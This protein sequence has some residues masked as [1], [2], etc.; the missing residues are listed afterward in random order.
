MVSED[1]DGVETTDESGHVSDSDAISFAASPIPSRIDRYRVERCLGHGGFGTV[2]LAQD[3]QL[4]RFVAIKVPKESIATSNEV[5]RSYEAE[6]RAVA[7]LD[8]PN[9][10][11]VYDIGS[12][13]EFPCFVVSKYIEGQ[14]LG[15]RLKESSFSYKSL[16][17]LIATIA[18]ALHYGHGRGLIHRDIKPR[19][20]L[21]D[22]DNVPYIVDYG[23]A[24]RDEDFGSGRRGAGT[25]TYMSPEQA[26]GESHLVDGRSDIFSL[27]I[28]FFEAL[29]GKRPFRGKSVSE[30]I[31]Q[32]VRLDPRP[33]RQIDDLV[34]RELERICLKALEKR[35]T[36]RYATASDMADD[37]RRFVLEHESDGHGP[38]PRSPDTP[39]DSSS[40]PKEGELPQ[41]Y[42]SSG[43]MVSVI[44]RGLRSFTPQDA[45]FY[46]SLVPGPRDRVGMPES[47]AAW[48]RRIV[49]SD[50]DD[51]IS[52][53]M[54]YGPSGCGKSSFVKAGLLP[55]LGSAVDVVFVEAAPS[56]TEARLLNG[57]R[58]SCS[59]IPLE[60]G[61]RDSMA[62]LRTNVANGR[63][64]LLVIDQFEQWLH[65]RTIQGEH[66]LITALRQCDGSGVQCIVL[67]RDDFWMAATRFMH[68]LD[69]RLLE[70]FNSTAIDTFSPA[71]AKRVLAAFARAYDRVPRDPDGVAQCSRFLDLAIESLT[72][73]GKLICVRLAV[74]AE[75][76]K[77]RPWVPASLD[78]VGGAK[79]LGVAFLDESFSREKAPL[80]NRYHH[81]AAQLVLRKLLPTHGA[82]IIGHMRS[83]EELF[84]ASGYSQS[85][86]FDA[87][88]DLLDKELRLIT[89][90]DREGIE[91]SESPRQAYFQLSHDFLVPS[92]RLWLHRNQKESRQGRAELRL[93]EFSSIWNAKPEKQRLPS[94]LDGAQIVF[95]TR[96]S[97]RSEDQRKM[98][99]AA[100]RHHATR[101]LFLAG[102]IF[103]AWM[104]IAELR[105]RARSGPLVQQLRTASMEHVSNILPATESDRRWI[106]EDLRRL[107]LNEDGDPEGALRARLALANE[108]PGHASQLR[109]YLPS[110]KTREIPVICR[111]LTDCGID[112]VHTMLGELDDATNAVE[113]RFN[114]A[115]CLS[116]LVGRSDG[117]DENS[118]DA[119][120]LNRDILQRLQANA[121]QIADQMIARVKDRP[122]E[123]NVL[124]TLLYPARES[125]LNGFVGAFVGNDEVRQSIASAI[126]VDYV[127]GLAQH[128]VDF[129]TLSNEE[130]YL[131]L[132]PMLSQLRDQVIDPLR[133][134][135]NSQD[136]A[137]LPPEISQAY[138]KANALVSLVLLGQ[139]AE[140][141]N[142]L[143]YTD[144][145]TVRNWL[146]H[147]FRP[148]GVNP[149]VLVERL[150]VEDND[151]LRRALIF[152]LGQYN[153]DDLSDQQRQATLSLAK[154]LF[155]N[156]HDA[157][158]HGSAAWLIRQWEKD[159]LTDLY[160]G[161][162]PSNQPLEGHNW[163]INREGHTMVV[164]DGRDE[165]NIGHEFEIAAYE[166]T[167]G[168]MLRWLPT[169]FVSRKNAPAD[170]CPAGL[171][172]WHHGIAYCQWLNE[173][174]GIPESEYCYPKF[175]FPGED[176]PRFQA[177]L[178]KTGYRL[179]T[180][181]EWEFACRAGTITNSYYGSAAEL[182][183]H[184]TWNYFNSDDRSHP[185]G[186]K[187][188]NAWGL[189][190]LHGNLM[191]WRADVTG[192]E[193]QVA[194]GGGDW[195]HTETRFESAIAGAAV[196]ATKFYS[197]GFR[198]ARTSPK[199]GM[200]PRD[201]VTD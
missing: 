171:M 1:H 130:Q 193:S 54:I 26:R 107:A 91:Q 174:M 167:T 155:S 127:A 56:E 76:M 12:T 62:W 84:E 85:S 185:V 151:G 111:R 94:L 67:I 133:D 150:L 43:D 109:D 115:L 60:L 40:V 65:S 189:F 88:M 80:Q 164:V 116:W 71:H 108:D 126:V 183:P 143:R 53:G 34:P 121:P 11:P 63:K 10:V 161:L 39:S 89:P 139:T 18:D 196:P 69:K 195:S 50:H 201:R 157:G 70:G 82:D 86:D 181:A 182:Y 42:S 113:R 105:G 168:Q 61:L 112:F 200:F 35:V 8:H 44:P 45:D 134:Q 175:E 16:A 19:N 24:L 159:S 29:V 152:A 104:G 95:H 23:L 47:V 5:L 158:V 30:I 173:Q 79:G 169:Q 66:E 135:I 90:S 68:E 136:K 92:L 194:I 9:I 146:I 81:K 197:Y 98:I 177:D 132:S 100:T 6:A 103:L 154:R 147:R 99:R 55:Q 3:E 46:L 52:M 7:A 149:S 37:L 31:K 2:Y 153:H 187:K 78:A 198:I 192:D 15:D 75:M 186:F 166:V 137:I 102:I 125:I 38:R 59:I 178:T 36:N 170:D 188:P 180:N 33:P 142:A 51:P 118:P 106:R 145:P 4:D 57:I 74:F 148:A 41:L 123:T 110:A 162:S 165:E 184:Y 179:P 140:A 191:E 87:L 172:T 49:D 141:W 163:Y 64:F 131:L 83:R 190:D 176:L 77:N 25:P 73:D 97:E 160:A 144:D 120:N 58:K 17:E 117:S 129:I 138:R 32:I 96:N 114:A 119:A 27:G 21:I 128:L 122:S 13:D 124:L 101:L 28:V 14:E 72:V 48:K 93:E 199:H 156:H 22:A 20:I